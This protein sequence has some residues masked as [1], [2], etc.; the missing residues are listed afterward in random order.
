MIGTRDADRASSYFQSKQQ[1]LDSEHGAPFTLPPQLADAPFTV[2]VC[3]QR[4]GDIVLFPPRCAHQAIN[5]RG[6]VGSL[7]WSRMTLPSLGHALYHEL[8]VYNRIKRMETYRV[9]ATVYYAVRHFA[10]QHPS[11]HGTTMLKELLRLLDMILVSEYSA[12]ALALEPSGNPSYDSADAYWL[13]CDVCYADI[14]VSYF[15]CKRCQWDVCPLCYVSGR[16]CECVAG[17]MPA[18]VVRFGDILDTRNACAQALSRAQ[19]GG[20][21]PQLTGVYGAF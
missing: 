11:T 14:F 17:M 15:E 10:T 8:P 16:G 19:D 13:S 2:Y 20:A 9:K 6:L 18:V 3:Q 21:A 1:S 4:R 7:S 5:H 12:I